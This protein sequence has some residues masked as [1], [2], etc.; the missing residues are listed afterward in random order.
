MKFLKFLIASR[1]VPLTLANFTVVCFNA[2]TRWPGYRVSLAYC[3]VLSVTL[4]IF[5]YIDL[6]KSR[7]A[8]KAAEKDLAAG[9]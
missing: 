4:A 5:S 7:H 9:K 2:S 1:I 3:N 8:L 6:L